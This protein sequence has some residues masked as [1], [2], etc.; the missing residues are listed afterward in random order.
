MH[1]R[2][3]VAKKR[4]YFLDPGFDALKKF[5]PDRDVV[6]AM[7]VALEKYFDACRQLPGL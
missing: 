4:G 3:F 7:N 1:A 6:L 5:P 2:G